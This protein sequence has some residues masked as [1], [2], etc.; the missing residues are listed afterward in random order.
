LLDSERP[1][2]IVHAASEDDAD[3]AEKSL[4]DACTVSDEASV[5]RPVVYRILTATG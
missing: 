1:L 5:E 4:L 3:R 2:A